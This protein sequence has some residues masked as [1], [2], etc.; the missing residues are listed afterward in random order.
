ME[1]KINDKVTILKS[2]LSSKHDLQST[3]VWFILHININWIDEY[4]DDLEKK[5]E[6]KDRN[7][8]ELLRHK[9]MEKTSAT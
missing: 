1:I 4:G 8:R 5:M 7:L 6:I 3:N 9:E 2:L